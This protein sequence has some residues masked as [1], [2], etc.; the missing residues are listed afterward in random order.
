MTVPNFKIVECVKDFR[1]E[2]AF[3][4]PPPLTHP[5][6]Q[7]WK[8]PSWIGLKGTLKCVLWLGFL[9][10]IDCTIFHE[11]QLLLQ[12]F[13]LFK[14]WWG[15]SWILCLKKLFSFPPFSFYYLLIK[16]YLFQSKKKNAVKDIIKILQAINWRRQNPNALL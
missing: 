8:D 12:F 9:E 3:C 10:K 5:R 15:H 4:P 16:L 14:I 11:L 6:E 13:T 7:P 2:W 1:E